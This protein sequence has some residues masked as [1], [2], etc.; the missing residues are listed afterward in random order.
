MTEWVPLV[1]DFEVEAT[2]L[3]V[4]LSDATSDP[5]SVGA[6]GP[7]SLRV[8]PLFAFTSRAQGSSGAVAT[9]PFVWRS[10]AKAPTTQAGVRLTLPCGWNNAGPAGLLH[11][12]AAGLLDGLLVHLQR[13]YALP[14]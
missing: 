11:L 4:P 13:R 5:L 14:E 2:T 6:S 3:A 8:F 12:P 7:S 9:M 1:R 10:H